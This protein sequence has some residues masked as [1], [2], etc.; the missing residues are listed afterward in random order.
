[1]IFLTNVSKYFD[2]SPLFKD[3]GISVHRGD[4][5]GIVGPNGAGKSTI[6]GMMEGVVTP[7]DGEISIEKKIRMGVLHQELIDGNDGPIVEEVMN[8][9]DEIR[10]IRER[11]TVLEAKM[12]ELSEYDETAEKVL[13][14]HGL[15]QHEFE[16]LADTRS[17]PGH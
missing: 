5:I 9:T 11:L 15:L 12:D 1:M 4:R 2:G 7:D 8:I 17:K 6:L 13:E 16:R 10:E 3:V 14:E